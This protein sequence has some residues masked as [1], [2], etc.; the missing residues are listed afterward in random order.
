[1]TNKYFRVGAWLLAISSPTFAAEIPMPQC[2]DDLLVRQEIES[3]VESG[4]KA[5][6]SHSRHKLKAIYVSDLETFE[7]GRSGIMIPGGVS[8]LPNGDEISYYEELGPLPI[9]KHEYWQLCA[10]FGTSAILSQR[11]PE[12]VRRCDVLTTQNPIQKHSIRC[13]DDARRP[14]AKKR[15]K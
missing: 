2:P 8:R 4:W 11:I 1:M 10:F 9:G 12:T 5:L 7:D 6:G 14:A 13:F 3:K 15:E